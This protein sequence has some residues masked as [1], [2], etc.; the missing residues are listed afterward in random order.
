MDCF[1]RL[2]LIGLE[3]LLVASSLFSQTSKICGRVVQQESAEPLSQVHIFIDGELSATSDNEGF[4][5]VNLT[6]SSHRWLLTH[7]GHKDLNVDTMF[8]SAEFLTFELSSTDYLLPQVDVSNRTNLQPHHLSSIHLPINQMLL[9]PKLLGEADPIKALS[10]YPGV[11]VGT[12]GSSGI[13]VRGGTP[14]QNLYLLD[15][16][17][18]YN[19]DHLFGYLSVVNPVSVK[20]LNLYKGR[21]PANYGGRTSSVVDMVTRQGDQKDFHWAYTVGLLSN[22]SVI[23]GPIHKKKGAFIIS[24]RLANLSILTAPAG[25]LFNARKLDNF[26]SYNL[27]DINAKIT[28][29]LSSFRKISISAYTGQDRIPVWNREDQDLRKRTTNYAHFNAALKYTKASESGFQKTVLYLAHFRNIDNLLIYNDDLT[30]KSKQLLMKSKDAS[31]L[32]EIG[33]KHHHQIDLGLKLSLFAGCDLSYFNVRPSQVTISSMDGQPSHRKSLQTEFLQVM[34]YAST[35]YKNDRWSYEIGLRTSGFVHNNFTD[36]QVEPRISIS[37]EPSEPYT[38][39]VAFTKLSQSLHLLTSTTSGLPRSQWI[40]S[41]DKL[42][43]STSKNV[44]IDLG[45][46]FSNG[47]WSIQLGAFYRRFRHLIDYTRGVQFHF[48]L[49]NDFLDL[50]VS[51]GVGRVRGLELYVETK[52]RIF[53][54]NLSLTFGRSERKFAAINKGAWIRNRFDKKLDINLSSIFKLSKEISLSGSCIMATGFPI[55]LPEGY[56]KGLFRGVNP[57]FPERFNSET[58]PYLRFD[59]QI[60]KKFVSKKNKKAFWSAGIYNVLLNFNPVKIELGGRFRAVGIEQVR[61]VSNVSKIGSAYFRFIPN[62]TLG[63]IF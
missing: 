1:G 41:D 17:P 5:C 36:I 34:P 24:S 38:I 27:Y 21:I 2:L 57:Y 42:P 60:T 8:D 15:D 35:L 33:L 25:L 46:T 13:Y 49:N 53:E 47:S 20:S 30:T 58:P 18:L 52:Q 6:P 10:I 11:S 48:N 12:E 29:D 40:G 63:R 51:D 37:F 23:E 59:V 44:S 55:T 28:H 31:L 43:P 7:L 39:D 3:I 61:Y 45:R 26:A 62:F 56:A 14:D 32:Q 50:I 9:Q 54:A 4:F 22:T 19:T 16:V